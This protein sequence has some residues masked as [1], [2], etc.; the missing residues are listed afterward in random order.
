MKHLAFAGL[1]ALVTLLG[2][3]PRSAGAQQRVNVA[4]RWETDSGAC[5]GGG[6]GHVTMQL[7]QSGNGVVWSYGDGSGTYVCA[8]R[9]LRCE[10]TWTRRSGSG[11]FS[12][13]FTPDGGAFS[14]TWGYA[15]NPAAPG[16]FGGHRVR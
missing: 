14:G 9:R 1:L 5:G 13:N 7:T 4:G 10:G 6:A 11:P 3:T 12:V 15:N 2:S 8:L 16:W